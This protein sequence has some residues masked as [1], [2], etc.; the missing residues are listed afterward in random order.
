MGWVEL[1][2]LVR[3]GAGLTPQQG[4]DA[5]CFVPLLRSLFV[6]V[7]TGGACNHPPTAL[8]SNQA[9][10]NPL[11]SCWDLLWE[12]NHGTREARRTLPMVPLCSGYGK[13]AATVVALR[14]R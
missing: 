9:T 1:L 11:V 12:K 6:D 3:G 8:P 10:R 2:A 5:P 4:R 14:R 7:G 13:A